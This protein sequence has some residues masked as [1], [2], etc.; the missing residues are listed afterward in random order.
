LQVLVDFTWLSE[1][2]VL[3]PL[4]GSGD[5]VQVTRTSLSRLDNGEFLDDVLLDFYMK[6]ADREI[7]NQVVDRSRR[8]LCSTLYHKRA[9]T[10]LLTKKEIEKV[11][12]LSRDVVYVPINSEL[13]WYLAVIVQPFEENGCI[14]I[15]DSIAT[16]LQ[17]K[18]ITVYR[19]LAKCLSREFAE[20]MK[21]DIVNKVFREPVVSDNSTRAKI[22]R[23]YQRTFPN[24]HS[25]GS[26]PEG[27]FGHMKLKLVR[28]PQQQNGC[29]CGVF[30]CYNVEKLLQLPLAELTIIE[31]QTWFSQEEVTQKRHEMKSLLFSIHQEH[32]QEVD[33][34]VRTF[35][36]FVVLAP[37]NNCVRVPLFHLFYPSQILSSSLLCKN[38]DVNLF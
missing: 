5:A 1:N 26:A 19:D 22:Q 35:S 20:M 24:G 33:A 32:S 9:I 25:I 4:D 34:Q 15:F 8:I 31:R 38:V 17:R 37:E 18:H 13:H 28:S 23:L 21:L 7:P 2:F 12:L 30:V 16:R 36:F 14:M 27:L 11:G 10:N 29:D 3:Y 6:F